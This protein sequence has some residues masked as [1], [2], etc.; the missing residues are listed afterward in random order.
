MHQSTQYK[1]LMALGL[2]T[3]AT[4]SIPDADRVSAGLIPKARNGRPD[5]GIRRGQ[6]AAR[7]RRNQIRARA[8]LK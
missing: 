3:A 4:A 1:A 6:R 7:K 5:R 8:A 2:V